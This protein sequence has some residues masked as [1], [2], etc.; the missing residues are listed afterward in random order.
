MP[1]LVQ[2]EHGLLSSQANFFPRQLAH[3]FGMRRFFAVGAPSMVKGGDTAGRHIRTRQS[4]EAV[5]SCLR[6]LFEEEAM[7]ASLPTALCR[8]L[9]LAPRKQHFIRV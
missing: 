6:F 2:R 4:G 8:F 5:R 3:A 1:A 9:P 7:L